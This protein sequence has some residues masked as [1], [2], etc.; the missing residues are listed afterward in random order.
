MKRLTYRLRWADRADAPG[1]YRVFQEGAAGLGGPVP[2][3]SILGFLTPTRLLAVL[4]GPDGIV[5]ASCSRFPTKGV[6]FHAL[7]AISKACRGQGLG[8]AMLAGMLRFFP[9]ATPFQAHKW[10]AAFPDY[11]VGVRALYA[12]QGWTQEGTLAKHTRKQTD[13]LVY[14]YYP[15]PE[16]APP[17]FWHDLHPEAPRVDWTS[18][19]TLPARV[20]PDLLGA[21]PIPDQGRDGELW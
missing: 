19:K 1:I 4:D 12:A 3:A 13:L 21:A 18:L 17:P 11:N 15:S 10:F 6:A 16:Q 20:K 14:A 2:T 5:G 7:F 8:G 9:L